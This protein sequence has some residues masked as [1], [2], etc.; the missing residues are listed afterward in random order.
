MGDTSFLGVGKTVD[1]SSVITV[2]TQFITAD[3]SSSGALSE[4]RRIYVQGGEVIGNSQTAVAGLDPYDSIT[5]DFC[6]AQ[7]EAFG[8]TNY[9]ATLGGLEGMGS[10]LANGHVLVM[11]IWDDHAVNMLWL[12]SDYP[13]EKD[14]SEPGVSRGEC[15]TDSGDPDTVEAES[16]GATVTFSNIRFGDIGTTYQ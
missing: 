15:A 10:S 14:A 16:P 1:T 3:N 5:D 7:K 4:I 6:A 13:P 9:F 11:S 2:V 8:D 12:D